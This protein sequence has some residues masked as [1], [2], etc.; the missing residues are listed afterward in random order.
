MYCRYLRINKISFNFKVSSVFSKLC[1]KWYHFPKNVWRFW[2]PPL[3][4]ANLRPWTTRWGHSVCCFSKKN[5]MY[6]SNFWLDVNLIYFLK[7]Q[8][9]KTATFSGFTKSFFLTSSHNWALV[10]NLLFIIWS[11][12]WKYFFYSKAIIFLVAIVRGKEKAA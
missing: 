2:K 11:R 1:H 4:K 12:K 6:L 7:Y 9:L 3:L 10:P 5:Q 8:R